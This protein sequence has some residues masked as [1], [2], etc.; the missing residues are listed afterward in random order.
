MIEY[1]KEIVSDQFEASLCMLGDC[2]QNCPQEHWHEKNVNMEFG[3]V[4]YHTLCFVDLYLSPDEASFQ[5][6]DFHNEQ[7]EDPFK[8]KPDYPLT[9]EIVSNYL[10]TCRQKA[11]DTVANETENS[12]KKESGFHWLPITRG[13]LHIY[14]IRHIQHHTGQLSAYLR[15]ID[16]NMKW[17]STGWTPRVT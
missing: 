12:L 6:R 1:F 9:Q 7:D 14:N 11:L 5:L 3:Y 16:I 13:E 17:V 10:K 15:R 8:P 2:I 4:A